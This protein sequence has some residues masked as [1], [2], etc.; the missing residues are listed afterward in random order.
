[1]IKV[2]GSSGQ[3]I[4]ISTGMRGQS[5]TH[6]SERPV[7]GCGVP[8]LVCLC[9]E[10][11]SAA[12][13]EYSHQIPDPNS[14]GGQGSSSPT[15]ARYSHEWKNLRTPTL[16]PPMGQYEAANGQPLPTIGVCTAPVTLQ[17]KNCPSTPM[18]FT[19]TKAASP[20]QPPWV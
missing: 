1:M 3:D 17:G 16:S 19:I 18:M 2:R 4:C 7:L 15:L 11:E 9:T 8:L 12:S 5:C 13:S 14:E 10:E 6:S 20:T